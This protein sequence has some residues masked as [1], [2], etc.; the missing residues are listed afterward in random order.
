MPQS[1]HRLEKPAA[2]KLVAGTVIS[3]T[4]VVS[5]NASFSKTGHCQFQIRPLRVKT[6]QYPALVVS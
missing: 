3:F 2:C 6:G 5:A 1:L 4:F